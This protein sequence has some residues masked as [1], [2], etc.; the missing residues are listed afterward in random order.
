MLFILKTSFFVHFDT[1]SGLRFLRA[2]RLLQL[3]EILQFLTILRTSNSIKLVSLITVFF[4][5]WLTVAGIVHLVRSSFDNTAYSSDRMR[6]GVVKS[7]RSSKQMLTLSIQSSQNYQKQHC[8]IKMYIVIIINVLYFIM[9]MS[10]GSDHLDGGGGLQL[11]WMASLAREPCP[12]YF[13]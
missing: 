1:F 4:S 7:S 13:L 9:N 5:M 8:H 10:S 3:S 11:R 12:G 6:K 2:L